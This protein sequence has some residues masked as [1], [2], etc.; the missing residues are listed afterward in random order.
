MRIKILAATIAALAT[1]QALAAPEVHYDQCRQPF[2]YGGSSYLGTTD[3]DNAGVQWCYLKTP[4]QGSTW[5]VVREESIPLQKTVSGTNCAATS[6]YLGE[7]FHGC[8]TRGHSTFWCYTDDQGSNWENCQGEDGGELLGHAQP[9][10]TALVETVAVGSCFKQQGSMGQAMARLTASQPDLFMWLGDNIYADTT[11]ISTMRAKYDAKKANPDYRAFLEAGI[12]V[13]ATWDDHDFGANN[14][15]DNY[16][17]RAESQ[18]EFLRHFDVPAD[19]PRYK[20]Q[21]GIYSALIQGPAG[22]R[23]HSIMLDARYHRSPTFSSY[24]QCRGDASTLLGETQWAWLEAELAKP[25]EIKII[26]SGIQVLPPLHRERSLSSYCAYGNGQAFNAAV[27]SLGES[28][29]SGTSYESWAE[30]PQ[31]RERLLRL[32]QKAINDGKAKQVIFVSGDQHWGELLQKDIPASTE[33]GPAVTVFEVTASG[34]G[35]N[36]PYDVP[37][38]NRLPVWADSQGDGNYG[39]QCVLPF[40]Y[41]GISYDSCTSRD[42]DRPWCYTQVDGNGNGIEGQ[43]GNCAPEGAAIPTGLVGKVPAE[44]GAV[45]TA[46]RHLINKTGSNYGQIDID[47]QQRRIRLSIQSETEEVAST[48]V[49]F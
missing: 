45:S 13:L 15:G 26:A 1:G 25:S 49:A 30:M 36:W 47:W 3:R 39:Q 43:W 7:T 33:H 23:V 38:P 32:V 46:D 9:Q 5:A 28:A 16:P 20:G 42:H 22:K 2:S 17:K 4:Q 10:A 40:K 14:A 19:D 41:Q 44:L 34:F 37:N 31:Q 27:E 6:S 48:L 24:G 29:L 11:D 12:P 8:S 18:Q 21:E 35:Q